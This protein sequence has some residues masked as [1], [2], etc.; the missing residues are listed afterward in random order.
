MEMEGVRS[1]P[2]AYHVAIE[3]ATGRFARSDILATPRRPRH[4][5]GASWS[6]ATIWSLSKRATEWHARGAARCRRWPACRGGAAAAHRLHRH[7][8][9]RPRLGQWR[10][11]ACGEPAE[12]AG[13]AKARRMSGVGR[14]GCGNGTAGPG[15]RDGSPS[16]SLEDRSEVSAMDGQAR[17]VTG[18]TGSTRMR[19]LDGDAKTCPTSIPHLSDVAVRDPAVLNWADGRDCMV[20]RRQ[21]AEVWRRPAL[22][23][24]RWGRPGRW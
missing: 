13:S 5:T 20:F 14:P 9:P 19:R 4:P 8:R 3:R 18:G 11:A 1:K 2:E 17:R 22:P 6:C 7:R 12:P 10:D 21:W 23:E 24:G 15:G 16:Q